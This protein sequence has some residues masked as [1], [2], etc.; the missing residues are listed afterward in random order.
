MTASIFTPAE[1]RQI[2]HTLASFRHHSF[3]LLLLIDRS[4]PRSWKRPLYRAFYSA[5]TNGLHSLRCGVEILARYDHPTIDL[6]Y[7]FFPCGQEGY[8]F[9]PNLP[10]CTEEETKFIH[11]SR[12]RQAQK[13]QR[14]PLTTAE[15][16][17]V[18]RCYSHINQYIGAI[19][20]KIGTAPFKYGFQTLEEIVAAHQ[21]VQK[22]FKKLQREEQRV[23]H[24]QA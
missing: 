12:Q 20:D 17:I 24:E 5:H 4:G 13:S 22:A 16:E 9:T 18:V 10:G 1:F 11:E 7:D 19:V 8:C 23:A 21:L 2:G 15:L 14:E 6:H 3:I